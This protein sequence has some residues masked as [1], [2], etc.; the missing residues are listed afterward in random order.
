MKERNDKDK[1][2]ELGN[3]GKRWRIE[4]HEK[5]DDY[6]IMG[7]ILLK[8]LL[9]FVDKEELS[10]LFQG[11]VAIFFCFLFFSFPLSYRIA[12]IQ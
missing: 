3:E 6:H 4:M 5:I 10:L 8:K 9:Q 1:K 7:E 11:V 2:G 12:V